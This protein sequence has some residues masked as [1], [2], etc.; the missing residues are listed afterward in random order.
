MVLQYIRPCRLLLSFFILAALLTA[1]TH[2]APNVS[3]T[4]NLVYGVGYVLDDEQES[5]V[6]KDLSFDLLEPT[7]S[8]LAERPALVLVHGGGFT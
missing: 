6:A 4:R 1:C 3:H 5:Y 2:L 7:D 8:P